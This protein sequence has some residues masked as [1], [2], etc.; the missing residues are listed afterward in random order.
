MEPW[1]TL[2]LL[3]ILGALA[4]SLWRPR[5][6]VDGTEREL[7]NPHLTPLEMK[8]RELEHWNDPGQ[9]RRR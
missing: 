5:R 8:Q 6:L 1:V 2:V 7:P 9:R 3:F 4:A